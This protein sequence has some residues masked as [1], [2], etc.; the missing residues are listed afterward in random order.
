MGTG[1]GKPVNRAIGA[2]LVSRC[3][4][5]EGARESGMTAEAK[6]PVHEAV[7]AFIADPAAARFEALALE[8]F[9]HQFACI[10]AYRR[11]CERHGKTPA[12]VSDWRD[13]PP[14]PAL[15]FK[16]VE[17]CCAPAERI[18]LTTGTT[19]GTERRGRLALP[20]LRL[21]R[22]A[23]VAGMKQFLFPDIAGLRILSLIPSAIEHP[24]SSLAQMVAWAIE[25]FGAPRSACLARTGHLDFEAVATALRD[26]ERDGAPVCIMTTTGALLRLFDH[27]HAHGWTFR[28]PHSSRVMDT[29]GGKGAPR[30]LSA[31]GM[32]HACWNTFATPGYF[33]ANE[34][35]MTEMS[36]QFYDNV[37]RDRYHGRTT[38][39]AKAGPHWVRTLV[40]DPGT[41]R[42]VAAGDRGLLCHFDLANAGTAMAVLTEDVGRVVPD[43]FELIGRAAGAEGR[44]CSLSAAEFRPE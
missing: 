2:G 33:C 22:A 44:G 7:L 32:L 19:A 17:L 21:Y 29:G 43:G 27:C 26:S 38:H 12:V 1:D 40:L 13:V 36:S 20:D 39:R 35:G 34:Y 4:K 14:V 11:V 23:A 28:L 8:V 18:F 42:P 37:I 10:P 16:E 9:A 15:A 6:H 30:P 31:R 25:D 41:L 3:G 24:E 5:V